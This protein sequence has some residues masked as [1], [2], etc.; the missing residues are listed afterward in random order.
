MCFIKCNFKNKKLSFA[1]FKLN[2]INLKQ[3]F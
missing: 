2:L 1:Q 3:Y